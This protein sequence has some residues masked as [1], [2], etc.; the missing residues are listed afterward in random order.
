MN[1]TI[2]PLLFFMLAPICLLAQAQYEISQDENHPE[3]KV[4]RGTIDKYLIKNDTSFKWYAS[5]QGYY[6]PDSAT[7]ATFVKAKDKYQFVVFGIRFIWHI[8]SS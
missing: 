6:N 5:S 3:V 1:K 8:S 7:I 4:L 2:L